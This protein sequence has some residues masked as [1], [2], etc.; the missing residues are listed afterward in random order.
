MRIINIIVAAGSGSRFGADKPKQFCT[1]AGRRVIDHAVARLQE[2]SPEA[3]TVVVLSSDW[4]D[5]MNDTPGV[6]AVG[7][8]ATRWESVRNALQATANVEADLILVH[9]GARPLPSSAMIRRAIDACRTHQGAI[10]VVAVVDSLRTAD[11]APVDRS[12]FRAVQTPQAFRADLLR[13]AYALPYC[14]SFTDDASVMTAAGF[15]DIAMV[16]GDARNLK[17]TLPMD[18]A[19]AQLY[20]DHGA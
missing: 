4:I 16:E 7:G 6:I 1:L 18:L 11:G 20:I 2:A 10:P 8:G 9:D 3:T 17:I 14:E 15:T 12:N 19:I 5:A 13:Q